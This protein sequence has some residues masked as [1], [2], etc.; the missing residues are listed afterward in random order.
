MCTGHEVALRNYFYSVRFG[1]STEDYKKIFI[2][3]YFCL[4]VCRDKMMAGSPVSN[5]GKRWR[6][7]R[8]QE[9]DTRDKE[10]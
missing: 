4:E 1:D 6:K 2:I 7:G 9:G 10:Q 5:S 3:F 8:R